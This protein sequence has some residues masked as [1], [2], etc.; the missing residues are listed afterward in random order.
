MIRILNNK[1]FTHKPKH[2]YMIKDNHY[3]E[4]K[5]ETPSSNR[6]WTG[7]FLISSYRS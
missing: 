3:I 4:S 5:T 2:L 6:T 1:K 7:S